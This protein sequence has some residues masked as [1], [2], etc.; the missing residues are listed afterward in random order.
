M[1]Q[2]PFYTS[3]DFERWNSS[4]QTSSKTATEEI[5][6][7]FQIDRDRIIFSYAFRRLQSKTQVFQSGDYD[8]YRTRLTHSIEVAKI[9]RSI[10]ENL[11]T[12]SQG[13]LAIDADLVEAAC[14]AH[15]LGHPPFGHIGERTLNA[16]MSP[17]G[18]FE[19]NAQTLRILTEL[20]FDRPSKPVGMQPSRA[21]LDS[22][23]KYKKTFT[24]CIVTDA[25]D[26]KHYPDNHFV[27][28]DQQDI[29]NWVHRDGELPSEKCLECQVMDWADDTAYSL[30]DLSDGIQAGYITP[31]KVE[32]WA[33][34][35][36]NLS[37]AAQ[38]QIEKLI[39]TINKQSYERRHA[40]KIG[41]F[42]RSARIEK[43]E[44][45]FPTSRYSLKLK[46]DEAVKEECNLYKSL[47]ID[48]IFKSPQVQQN[49]YRGRYLLKRLFEA[50][51]ETYIHAGNRGLR[52]LPDHWDQR[53]RETDDEATRYRIMC[54]ALSSFTDGEAIRLYQRLFRADY[55]SLSDMV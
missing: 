5:R 45:T 55:G 10:V 14:L 49:E 4:A 3:V 37:S 12:Q 29:L 23:L 42:I 30:N 28:D 11:N 24:E 8:F 48:L 54:D 40:A 51:E 20:I 34:N 25:Q 53:V 41:A 33:E 7:P 18:G 47:A 46:I 2:T 35:K 36:T 1:A 38:S 43:T 21:L 50:L 22:I 17:W 16:C 27:Y 32:G 6:S 19:G 9:G 15:D 31:Q 52:I 26:N 39:D 44:D 13:T